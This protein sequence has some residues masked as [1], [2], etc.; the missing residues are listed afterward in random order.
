LVQDEM[1]HLI[2]DGREV[3]VEKGSTILTAAERLGIRIPTLCHDKRLIPF[4]AC[5]MCIVEEKG[6]KGRFIPACFTPVREGMEIVT[7]SPEIRS[8]RRK[9]LE[10]MLLDHPMDCPICDKRGDCTL[11]ALVYESGLGDRIYPWE[12]ISF[13]V[14]KISPF[15]HRDPNKCILCGKCVRICNEVQGIGALGFIGR[16]LHTRIG[17]AYDQVLDCEF[18]GQCIDVCPVGALTSS[19]FDYETRWWELKETAT[20]CGFCGC[21]C[22][23]MVGCKDGK[24][25]RVEADTDRGV[26]EGNLCVKGRFGWDYIHSGE[27][28]TTPLIRKNGSLTEASWEEALSFAAKRLMEIKTT[29]GGKSIAGIAS[30]RLTN[31]ECYL[32]QKLMRGALS[33]NHIDHAGG[34]GYAGLLGLKESLGYAATTNSISEIRDADVIMLIRCNP[35]ETHPLVKIE[36]NRALRD[37]NP[38]LIIINSIDIEI[39][40]PVGV[41]PLHK[42]LLSLLHK[43]GT[44]VALLNGMIQVIVEEG[45]VDEK[46]V[47]SYTSSVEEFKKGMA[48]Y[49]PE[50]VEKI[51]GVK[52][53]VIKETAIAYA[54]GKN[55]VI[56]MGSGLGLMGDEKNLAIALSGLAL[57][58]GKV[59]KRGNGVYF[60]GDKCN[61]QGALDMGVTPY[62]LPGYQG[63]GDEKVRK[64]F[65]TF[66]ETE[67]PAHKEGL[68]A[69]DILKKAEG[70]KIKAL[71]L[72]GVNPVA[73]YPGYFQ[74][75]DALDEL[76]FL[77]VQDLF[78]TETA[79]H[80]DVVLPALSF[81]EKEG[82]Y[83]NLERRVQK[84]NKTI[85]TLEGCKSD[86]TIFMELS[87]LLGYSMDYASPS[88][89]MEEINRLVPLYGGIRY[90]RLGSAGLQWPCKDANHPGTGYLYHD[91]FNDKKIRF[92]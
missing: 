81:A 50:Y 60:L 24:I 67:L 69:L 41:S 62:F 12:R 25:R 26:N 76:D 78:L 88:K 90:E 5:R 52:A 37:A 83:T 63:M 14:D 66:W 56:L 61:S 22:T 57:I 58:T 46:F 38:Q 42:P 43:P 75:I 17:T 45:L 13:P 87:Q 80:A 29:L 59:G 8:S 71:Y 65:E 6:R 51:T 9:K 31:E 7:D 34:Y 15:I 10:L 44:D 49:T 4:G 84:L 19:L 74:T 30:E 82:T 27:R 36:L 23:L 20:V 54:K 77:L 2:I 1:V 89:V 64:R 39:K 91:G 47:T 21:G 32:F 48:R 85:P 28:L 73:T 92:W 40:R 55:S 68:G 33:T 72:V 53:A 86:G 79:K 18:C 3:T 70:G 11:Q 35:F 16:G